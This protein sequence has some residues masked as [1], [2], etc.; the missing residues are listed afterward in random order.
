MHKITRRPRLDHA[1]ALQAVADYQLIVACGALGQFRAELT[2]A[3][4]EAEAFRLRR[5]IGAHFATEVIGHDL[6]RL[7]DLDPAELIP[8]ARLYLMGDD[9]PA[10]VLRALREFAER[11][12]RDGKGVN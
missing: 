6:A 8:A 10:I 7:L 3:Y 9:R 1:T 11:L 12:R 2:V 4:R 5:P